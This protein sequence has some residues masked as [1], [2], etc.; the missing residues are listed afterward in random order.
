MLR[1]DRGLHQAQVAELL[2]INQASLS[3]L[4]T[5]VRTPSLE[6]AAKI[7]REFGIKAAE[8]IE[9]PAPESTSTEAV[10]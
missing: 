5:G 2:G 4:E 8:W 6:L 9:Q 3:N 7:E 1:L 10:A